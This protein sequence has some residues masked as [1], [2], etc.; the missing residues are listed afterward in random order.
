MN[1]L[2]TATQMDWCEVLIFC[3]SQEP[4]VAFSSTGNQAKDFLHDMATHWFFDSFVLFCIMLNTICLTLSWYGEPEELVG[5][6]DQL[7]V[8]FNCIYSVEFLI[9]IIAFGCDYFNDGWNNFDFTI[10][11]TAWAGLIAEELGVDVGAVATV[12]R[13]F[14]ISRIFKIVKKFKSLRILF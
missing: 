11:V 4:I 3:Y 2:L 6:I 10:V 13:S 1:H 14:R 7:A 9:K 8:V 12:L 5:I